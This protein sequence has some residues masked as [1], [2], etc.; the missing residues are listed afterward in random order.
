[1]TDN[2][3]QFII[4]LYQNEGTCSLDLTAEFLHPYNRYGTGRGM[5]CQYCPVRHPQASIGYELPEC[6]ST[7]AFE[8]VKQFMFEHQEDFLEVLL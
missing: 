2:E 1:M 3:K 7:N 8:R 6:T 5:G 4:A